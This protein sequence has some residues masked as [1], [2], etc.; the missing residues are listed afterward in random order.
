LTRPGQP[1]P[2]TSIFG[3]KLKLPAK[4]RPGTYKLKLSFKPKGSPTTSK[5]TLKIRFVGPRARKSAAP[6]GHT[7]YRSN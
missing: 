5:K 6:V 2:A 7:P 3:F 4:L 1:V